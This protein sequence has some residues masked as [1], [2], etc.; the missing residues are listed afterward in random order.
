MLVTLASV[1]FGVGHFLCL[2]LL[3]QLSGNTS[4]PTADIECTETHYRIGTLRID[5]RGCVHVHVGAQCTADN[6]SML[7]M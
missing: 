2:L 1:L 6:R 3:L 5:A 7:C 4:N